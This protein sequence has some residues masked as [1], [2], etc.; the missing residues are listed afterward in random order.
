MSR[1]LLHAKWGVIQ[2]RIWENNHP[3]RI[4]IKREEGVDIARSIHEGENGTH[5]GWKTL[6][7]QISH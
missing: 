5:Q 3:L 7:L 6:Y 4:C 2:K 1:T